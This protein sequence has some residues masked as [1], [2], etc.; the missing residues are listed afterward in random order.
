LRPL[1]DV[2]EGAAADEVDV[3]MLG[4]EAENDDVGEVM[5]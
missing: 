2:D 5:P 1:N 4:D 3:D